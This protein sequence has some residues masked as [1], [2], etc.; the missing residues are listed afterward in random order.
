P[1]LY[2]LEPTSPSTG[3]LATLIHPNSPFKNTV[4]MAHDSPVLSGR[5]L[6]IHCTLGTATLVLHNVY[7]SETWTERAR[8]F[9]ALPRDFP[10]HFLHVV[11]GDFNCTLNKNLDSLSPSTKTMAETGELTAWMSALSVVDLFR[12]QNPLRKTFTSPKLVNQLDYI[13]CSSQLTRLAHWKTA[14]IPHIPNTD[15]APPWLLRFPRASTI[16]HNCLDRFLDKSSGFHNLGKAYDTLVTD[17]RQQLKLFHEEQLDKQRLSLKK[18]A[19]EIAGLLNV[20][21]MRQDPVLVDRVRDLQRQIHAL[22]D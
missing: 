10:P 4:E 9:D 19:L 2:P 13:F 22:H 16:V 15:H 5:Y 21:N 3:G 14:H 1:P 17:I 18:L 8:F 20:P 6:Q 7:A 12:Q 11:G